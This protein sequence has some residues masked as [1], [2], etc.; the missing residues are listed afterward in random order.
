MHRFLLSLVIVAVCSCAKVEPVELT[1]EWPSKAG[2]YY[3]VTDKWTR[4]GVLRGDLGDH[5]T[6]IMELH[7]TFHSPEWKQAYVAFRS[8]REKLPKSRVSTLLATEKADSDKYYDVTLLI[9]TYHFQE[10]DLQKNEDSVWRV[11][12]V[13]AQ[14]NEVEP[15]EVSSVRRPRDQIKAFFPKL[16]EFH[17]VYRARFPKQAVDL[18]ASGA[19][20]FSLKVASARGGLELIWKAK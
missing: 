5:L 15:E 1:S 2:N 12:L 8:K 11:A 13:D 17:E 14:G 3:D 7:A 16:N 4:S 19:N 9:S 18:F 20:K 6:N 10:N